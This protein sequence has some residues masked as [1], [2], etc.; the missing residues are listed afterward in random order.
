MFTCWILG[1]FIITNRRIRGIILMLN[2]IW[3]KS[4]TCPS[5]IKKHM[6]LSHWIKKVAAILVKWRKT[7]Q[8][9]IWIWT[10]WKYLTP[11]QTCYPKVKSILKKCIINWWCKYSKWKSIPSASN[12]KRVSQLDQKEVVVLLVPTIISTRSLQTTTTVGNKYKDSS[13]ISKTI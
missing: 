9:S 1:I 11:Q 6:A 3:R 5:W 10:K 13:K 12:N 7:W 4:Q 2:K 8:I